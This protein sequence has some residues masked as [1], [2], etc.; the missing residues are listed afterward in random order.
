MATPDNSTP[1]EAHTFRASNSTG[2]KGGGR[3]RFSSEADSRPNDE[4]VLSDEAKDLQQ[5][6][7]EAPSGIKERLEAAAHDEAL[8]IY[9]R[10]RQI[11]AG[12]RMQLFWKNVEGWRERGI[13]V[14]EE[15][16]REAGTAARHASA[17]PSKDSYEQALDEIEEE[18]AAAAAVEPTSP[19]RDPDDSLDAGVD[20]ADAMPDDEP[21][22]EPLPTPEEILARAEHEAAE[23]EAH[24]VF[25][26]AQALEEARRLTATRE[27]IQAVRRRG[28]TISRREEDALI[29]RAHAESDAPTK[30]ALE[31][32]SVQE[33]RLLEAYEASPLPSEVAQELFG[34]RT[35]VVDHFQEDLQRRGVPAAEARVRAAM[36]LERILSSGKYSGR[37]THRGADRTFREYG[38]DAALRVRDT[39]RNPRYRKALGWRMPFAMTARLGAE[40]VNSVAFS[41]GK[42]LQRGIERRR[43]SKL[44]EDVR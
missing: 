17:K 44:L 3:I 40:V 30:E 35:Q 23:T 7:A 10:A 43:F 22:T 12:N 25:E 19:D 37:N 24:S 34:R 28:G 2:S 26:L 6:F 41:A 21:P 20:G 5:L 32:A 8:S 11:D 38:K 42:A 39:W 29:D 18:R 15:D 33:S 36:R 16:V 1:E 4:A 27:R 9:N 13:E 31:A 14:T